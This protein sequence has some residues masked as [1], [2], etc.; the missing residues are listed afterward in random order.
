MTWGRDV[1]DWTSH[2]GYPGANGKVVYGEGLLVGYRDFDAHDREPAFCFGHGLSYGSVAWGEVTGWP[3]SVDGA[4]LDDGIV[5]RV[6]LRND[7]DRAATEVVQCYVA[8]PSGLSGRPPKELRAFDKVCLDPGGSG[9]AVLRL[10]RRSFS[11]WDPVTGTW[12]L[13]A[14]MQTVRL[15]RSSRDLLVDL[16]LDVRA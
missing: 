11:R 7:G 10:D 13:M 8:P 1:Q 2:Q 16:P 15:G 14:G 6:P 3:G 9:E 4:D 5:L 12:V